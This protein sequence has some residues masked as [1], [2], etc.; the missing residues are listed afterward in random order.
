MA[1]PKWDIK[2]TEHKQGSVN[3]QTLEDTD[4]IKS[5]APEA[6]KI[7]HP[8][9]TIAEGD[10]WAA[11]VVE[12][13]HEAKKAPKEAFLI[14]LDPDMRKALDYARGKASRSKFFTELLKA[15]LHASQR[16]ANGRGKRK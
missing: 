9:A 10:D 7:G 2:K 14:R 6:A 16:D 4:V 3:V 13:L 8:V 11:R 15:Y 12:A 1:R 5:K